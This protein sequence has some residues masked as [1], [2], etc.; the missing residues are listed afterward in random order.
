M[1]KKSRTPPPPRRPVQAPKRRVDSRT[2]DDRRRLLLLVAFAAAGL[3]ALA[4]VIGLI[5]LSGGT[6]NASSADSSD[7]SVTAAMQKVGCT[8]TNVKPVIWEKTK[9]HVPSLDTKVTWNTY[10][11][12]AGSHYPVPAVWGFYTD[13]VDPIRVVHNEEHGGVVL[14]WGPQA[15]QS[16][17]DLMR[18]F[19]NEDPVSMFGTPV[20]TI[21]GKSLGSKVAI[22]A[23][24]GDVSHY[25]KNG[26]YGIA[27]AAVCPRFDESAFKKFRDAYKGKGPEG[28]PMSANQ[29]GT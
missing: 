2:A 11:P 17:I 14:W 15:P 12:A 10:P 7:A 25:T 3:V 21:A 28:I 24:T 20:G 23:W 18:D 8:V 13:P 22:T 4:V 29:P 9:T 16:Q 1:A 19:Y 6:N 27:H 5:A 26:D